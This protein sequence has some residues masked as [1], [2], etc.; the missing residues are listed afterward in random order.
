MKTNKGQLLFGVVL[1]AVVYILFISRN[2]SASVGGGSKAQF[3]VY[4]TEWCGYTTKQRDALGDRHTY[5]DCDLNKDKCQGINGFP[6]TVNN[7]TGQR[8][9]GFNPN[10]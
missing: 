2:K 6:V 8:H 3:T 4:G 10:L 9:K 1:G 5:I 7:A